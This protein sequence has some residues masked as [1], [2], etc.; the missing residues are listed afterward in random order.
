MSNLGFNFGSDVRPRTRMRPALDEYIGQQHLLSA[1]KPLHQAIRR[2]AM[3]QFN[4]M[5]SAWCG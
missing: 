5:R 1:D 2:G 3:P 4:F